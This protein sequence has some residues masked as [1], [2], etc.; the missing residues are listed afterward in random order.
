MQSNYGT[1]G[2]TRGGEIKKHGKQVGRDK[3]IATG[4]GNDTFLGNV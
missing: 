2:T 1:N 4:M 3:T